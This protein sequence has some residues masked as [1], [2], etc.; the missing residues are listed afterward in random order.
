MA[1]CRNAYLSIF[2]WNSDHVTC[3]DRHCLVQL[4]VSHCKSS[5]Q[6]N[7]FL[8]PSAQCSIRGGASPLVCAFLL[9]PH[10]QQ[11]LWNQLRRGP[12]SSGI[13]QCVR[14]RC[15]ITSDR[16][17]QPSIS[18]TSTMAGRARRYPCGLDVSVS[19]IEDKVNLQ[20]DTYRTSRDASLWEHA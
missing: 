18:I 11:Q 14:K 9:S 7:V 13:Q 17:S 8:R 15:S 4:P 19:H 20:T 5:S 12:I 2:P 10:H 16:F 3:I 6:K 1:V